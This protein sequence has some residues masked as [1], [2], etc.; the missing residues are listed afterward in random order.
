MNNFIDRKQELL[1]LNTL[2]HQ[3]EAQLAIL[4]GRRRL[5]KT[6]LLREFCKNKPYCYYMADKAGEQSQ[7]KSLTLALAEALNEPFLQ[8]AE[9]Q[10]WYHIFSAFDRFRS[11]DK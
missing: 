6:T 10:E 3:P 9:N 2:Y 8:T 5:G 11:A 7:K 1:Q 4:Y